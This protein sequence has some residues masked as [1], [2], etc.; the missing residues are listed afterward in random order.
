MGKDYYKILEVSRDASPEEIK[1]AYRK[2]AIK[3]H[4]DKNPD[5]KDLATEKFKEVAEAYDTLS[6]PDKRET[7]N[8]YGSDG[9]QQ[10]R[11]GGSRESHFH[12]GV[13][14][15]DIFRAFFGGGDPFDFADLFDGAGGQRG[16][17]IRF[18]SFG[19]GQ[20]QTFTFNTGGGFGG[21]S[22]GSFGGDGIQ[23]RS[24][25]GQARRQAPRMHLACTLEELYNGA[26]K[27]RQVRN[28]TYEIQVPKGSKHGEE[29]QAKGTTSSQE[30]TFIISEQPHDSYTRD[31]NNLKYTAV[32]HPYE[33]LLGCSINIPLI[34]NTQKR[35]QYK[36]ILSGRILEKGLGMMST[37]GRRGDLV[38]TASF[39]DPKHL[40]TA[41]SIGKML[42]SLW[43]ITLI[44]SNPSILL[45]IVFL[46]KLF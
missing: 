1:K 45:L 27:K 18:T 32:V 44:W 2:L 33:W 5:N 3:W 15:N 17:N 29:V 12:G 41:M 6:D 34:D 13:D 43:L 9:V 37:D 28:D 24:H 36:G 11:S 46:R 8:R 20:G 35:I 38:I 40:A 10:M 7:F 39:L 16:G 22:F 21:P 42:F 4:P 30:I 25:G 23:F 31:G 19:G 26:T 14:P